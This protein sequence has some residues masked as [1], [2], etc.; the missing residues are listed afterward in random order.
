IEVSTSGPAQAAVPNKWGFAYVG[1]PAVAGVPALAHQAGSWPA[2]LHVHTA[3]GAAAG[4]VRVRFPDVASRG[5]VVHVTAVNQGPVW[6]QA[7]KWGPS[8]P[9]ELVVVG[10]FAVGGKPVFSRFT[11]LF[12]ASTR[13]P[14]PAGRG[15]GYV[16]YRPGGVAARFNSSGGAVTVA[17]GP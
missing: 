9:D 1:H 3:P 14:F 11:V 5:G 6:G 16:H 10:C 8:G 2:P 7:L 12:T 4:Q 17:A 15:Y 13:G